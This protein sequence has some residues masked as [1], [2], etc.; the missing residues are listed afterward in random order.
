[1]FKDRENFYKYVLLKN[2][3]NKVKRKRKRLQKQTKS[4]LN[5]EYKSILKNNLKEDVN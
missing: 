3:K 5:I 4:H 1:M 2:N